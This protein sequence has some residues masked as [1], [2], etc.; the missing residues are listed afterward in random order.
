MRTRASAMSARGGARVRW[1]HDEHDD[2]GRHAEHAGQDDHADHDRRGGH[3][4]C[5]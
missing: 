1:S 2:Y 5:C 3:A 4:R